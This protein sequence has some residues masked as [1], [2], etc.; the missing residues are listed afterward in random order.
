M[1][2]IYL[3]VPG[4]ELA[5]RLVGELGADGLEGQSIRLFARQP[6]RLDDLSVSV[7][8]LRPHRDTLMVR[9][10]TGAALALVAALLAIAFGGPVPSAWLLLAAATIAGAALGAVTATWRGD[11]RE[12]GP[13][14]S[15][16]RREDVVMLLHVPDERLEDVQKGIKGRHPEVRV[17]GTDPAGS[18]PFP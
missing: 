9:A 4:A 1:R 2:Q 18:P 11:P 8:G 15:E 17:K 10:L 5:R 13:L 12:L 14:R 7:N 16:L 6:G 3:I